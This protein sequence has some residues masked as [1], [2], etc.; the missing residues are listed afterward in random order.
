L[1][2]DA[3]VGPRTRAALATPVSFHIRQVELNIVRDHQRQGRDRLERYVEVNVPAFE[4]R[5][6]E[7]GRLALRSRVIVGELDNQTP[8]FDDRIRH[9]E[10]NP[11]WYVPKDIVPELL[12]DARSDPGYFSRNDFIVRNDPGEPIRLVQRPGPRNALG[13]MKFLFPNHHAVYLHDTSQRGLFGRSARSLSHGCVRVEKHKELALAL[14]GRDGWDQARLDGAIARG[15]TQRIDLSTTVPIFLDYTTAFLDEQENL[16]LLEDLYGLDAGKVAVFDEKG[17][18]EQ[19]LA[20]P[21]QRPPPPA[22]PALEQGPL[23][24]DV[25]VTASAAVPLA[26]APA[27]ILD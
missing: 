18:R 2:D 23:P 7:H 12:E 24:A 21:M 10:L 20:V 3:V 13:Q 17:L 27:A 16:H 22:G 4:L 1:L 26:P 9:I 6:V 19:P 14:L 15:R 5:Y 11:Y 8:I 25:A